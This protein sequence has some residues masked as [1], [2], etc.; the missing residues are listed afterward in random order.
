MCV[1]SRPGPALLPQELRGGSHP[2]Q[3]WQCEL[4]ARED[5]APLE[6][7]PCTSL[8]ETFTFHNQVCHQT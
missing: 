1:L 6:L 2:L 3:C 7:P 4:P 8:V 5:E